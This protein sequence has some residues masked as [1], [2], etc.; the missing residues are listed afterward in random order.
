MLG[1]YQGENIT[2][3]ITAAE[4]LQMKGTYLTDSYI[5]DGISTAFNPGRMEII[6]EEPR[7]LLDG[8]HNPA[9]MNMLKKT[10]KEDFEYER[11]IL[12][13]GILEDKD[14]HSMLSVIIPLSDVIIAT[15]S[16]NAR[17]C[18]STA[19]KDR[20]KNIGYTKELYAKDSL[21]DAINHA[22][23]LA[24]KNDLICISGSLFTVGEA[25][26]YFAKSSKQILR[27]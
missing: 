3:A 22:R 5:I 11:L 23:S 26:S 1:K 16:K 27:S 2:L 19:L 7:I 9:G 15:K 6:S 4:Q 21:S 8:A 18:G 25:R 12:V 24:H 17:A 13:I 10:L 14:I 20:I